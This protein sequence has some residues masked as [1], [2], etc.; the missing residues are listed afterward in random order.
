MRPKPN[1]DGSFHSYKIAAQDGCFSVASS[2]GITEANIDSFN[3]KTWGWA[4][5]DAYL[6]V[7]QLI[8]LSTGD[9]PCPQQ[10]RTLPVDP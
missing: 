5:C 4:G 6:Q 8:Y 10:S 3:K 7:G 9:P 1:P 2:F